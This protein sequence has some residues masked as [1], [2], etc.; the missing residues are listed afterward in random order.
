MPG[1]SR[2]PCLHLVPGSEVLVL[3]LALTQGL[4]LGVQRLDQV[5]VLQA[6]EGEL[7]RQNLELPLVGGQ[8]LAALSTHKRTNT[9]STSQW[10]LE[11]ASFLRSSSLFQDTMRL[12]K[13]MLSSDDQTH[14]CCLY[15]SSRRASP[16][17]AS[18]CRLLCTS[19]SSSRWWAFLM[20]SI[21][22][23][24]HIRE[25]HYLTGTHTR[26]D[27]LVAP[28]PHRWL[29]RRSPPPAAGLVPPGGAPLPAGGAAAAPQPP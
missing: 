12:Q 14:L 13:A 26:S 29:W 7:L 15:T 17:L 23:T 2:P 10:E 6:A 21:A 19:L 4:P 24:R 25:T 9:G 3:L 5:S 11:E 8:L 28:P 22:E 1:A 16:V 27:L 18:I 20:A